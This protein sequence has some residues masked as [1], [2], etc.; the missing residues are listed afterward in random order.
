MLVILRNLNEARLKYTMNEKG[1]LVVMFN[2]ENFRPYLVGFHVILHVALM[3]L[4]S[5][6]D[7]K[8]K[9]FRWI[10]LL[11]E[12]DCEI[13]DGKGYEN[14]VVGLLSQLIV[15]KAKECPIFECFSNKQVLMVW[16][17]L[18]HDKLTL[19]IT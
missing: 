8:P 1:F 15:Q 6:K 7:A 19:S 5:K 12:F 2:F 13:W 18:H 16:F 3:H 14:L 11:Q 9:L 17:N 4:F 10:S